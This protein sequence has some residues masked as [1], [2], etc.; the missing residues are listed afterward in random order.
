ME[1]SSILLLDRRSRRQLTRSIEEPREMNPSYSLCSMPETQARHSLSTSAVESPKKVSVQFA[2]HVVAA[3]VLAYLLSLA[4]ASYWK[5]IGLAALLGVFGLFAVSSIYWNW[6]GFPNAFFLAQGV[7]MIVGWALAGAVI[8]KLIPPV[9][10]S[11]Y[12]GT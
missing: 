1:R 9:R 10:T 11:S 5:R 7:D 2:S 3:G 8:A 12:R 6:Y 4:V